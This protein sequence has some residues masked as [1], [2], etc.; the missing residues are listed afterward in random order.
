MDERHAGV[1]TRFDAEMRSGQVVV[2][3]GSSEAVLGSC[4]TSSLDWVY[5]DGNHL[6]EYVRTD[7]ALSLRKTQGRRLDHR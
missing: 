3:R 7:L 1:L 6:Y 4:P 5:I 2:D